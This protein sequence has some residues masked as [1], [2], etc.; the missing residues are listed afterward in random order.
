MIISNG[1]KKNVIKD[2]VEEKIHYRLSHG[3]K[4]YFSTIN[5][6]CASIF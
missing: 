5:E 2:N 1:K 4:I 6:T 3:V